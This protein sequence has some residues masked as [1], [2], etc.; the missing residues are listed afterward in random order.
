MLSLA[1]H[2]GPAYNSPTP[3]PVGRQTDAIAQLAHL[4]GLGNRR[5]S[6]VPGCVNCVAGVN[7]TSTGLSTGVLVAGALAVLAAGFAVYSMR[8]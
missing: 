7:G 4:S 2:A 1:A 3:A 6:P 8:K 5:I